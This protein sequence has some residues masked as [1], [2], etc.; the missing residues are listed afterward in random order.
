MDTLDK[1]DKDTL[2]KI[3]QPIDNAIM[4]MGSIN[5]ED[6]YYKP[7]T[8]GVRV[9]LSGE[10]SLASNKLYRVYVSDKFIG[11]G[12]I[13]GENDRKTLKMEKVLIR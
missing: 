9:E 2:N 7:L 8:N 12:K 3:I 4:F 11:I 6:S 10:L 1:M 13:I 5:L